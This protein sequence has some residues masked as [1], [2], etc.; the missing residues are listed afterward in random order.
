MCS[1]S[2]TS[3]PSA[4]ST[5]VPQAWT[6]HPGWVRDTPEE[7]VTAV[8]PSGSAVRSSASRQRAAS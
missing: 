5:S 1:R 4:A 2:S 3:A 6:G 7:R 8:A